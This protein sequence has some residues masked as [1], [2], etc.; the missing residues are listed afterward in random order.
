VDDERPRGAPLPAASAARAVIILTDQERV[1]ALRRFAALHPSDDGIPVAQLA[2]QVGLAVRTAQRWVARY[3]AQG[4]AGL[5]RKERSDAGTRRLPAEQ[6]A[7]IEGLALR[8]PQPS[9]ATIHRQVA[10][11]ARERGWPVPSYARVYDIVRAL[12]P[13]LLTLAH[14]GVK[15]YGEAYDLVVRR[16]AGRPN[17]IWQADHTALDLWVRDDKGQPARPWLTIVLDDYSRAVAGYALNLQPPSALQTAL[18][19]RQAIWRKSEPPGWT[20]CGIP[21]DFYTDHGSDFTSHHLEQV[22]ADLH[23][24]LVFSIP[25]APRGRGKIE[26]FFGTINTM[27]L[28]TLPGYTPPGTAPPLEPTLTLSELD[29]RVRAFIVEDYH[30]QPHSET[31][32]PPQARWEASGFLPRLPETVEQLDLLLLTVARTRRVQRD[33]IHFAGLRFIDPTLAAYVGDDV[34]IRYDPRDMAEIRVYRGDAFLC[35]AVCQ[36]LAGQMVGFKDI[37]RA[38]TERRR[39]LRAALS[40]RDELVALLLAVHHTDP[41]LAPEPPAPT[42]GPRL[43]RYVND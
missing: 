36:D 15:A 12:A 17:E 32:E 43:K 7:L 40:E 11:I 8:R 16:E 26:R 42:V 5:V 39:H 38:R 3:R 18:A 33:G 35:R 28:A 27:F 25:G 22:A 6:I 10:D 14:A 30:R 37:I 29:G 34:V 20:V 24:H 19:L 13:A 4:L 31:G 21:R 9:V 2:R 23:I 1:E 41:P